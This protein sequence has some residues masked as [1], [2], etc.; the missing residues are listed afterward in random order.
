MND[1]LM[2]DLLAAVDQQM[3]SPATRYVALAYERLCRDGLDEQEAKEQ[4]A[5]CLGEVM[6]A[7]MRQRRGFDEKA[8]RKALDELPLPED[9]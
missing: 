9:V 2:S 6:D 3:V 1:D 7:M 8:Y 5:C 4:I